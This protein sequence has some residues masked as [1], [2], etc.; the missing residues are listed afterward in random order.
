MGKCFFFFIVFLAQ[1][2][3][4][5]S[6]PRFRQLLARMYI[7]VSEIAG[8]LLVVNF[9]QMRKSTSAILLQGKKNHGKV[10]NSTTNPLHYL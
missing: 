1:F 3:R 7:D 9:V 6:Y 5:L 10:P 4:G 2:F 8:K